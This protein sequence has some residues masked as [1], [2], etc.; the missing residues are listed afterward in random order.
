MV[1][2]KFT[3]HPIFCSGVKYGDRVVEVEVSDSAIGSEVGYIVVMKTSVGSTDGSG[4]GSVVGAK[5][6]AVLLLEF[7]GV[8]NPAS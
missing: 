1:S 5:V 7:D 8:T 4:V 6:P 2:V 3:C